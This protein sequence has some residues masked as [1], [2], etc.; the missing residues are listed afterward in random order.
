M[1]TV[2]IVKALDVIED[3]QLRLLSGHKVMVV[4]LLIL[5]IGVEALRYRY[6]DTYSISWYSI[7]G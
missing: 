1:N 6:S 3:R 4:H 7:H 2:A 5:Q